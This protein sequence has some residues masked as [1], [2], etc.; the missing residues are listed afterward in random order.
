MAG[1]DLE[2]IVADDELVTRRGVEL[3]LRDSGFRIAG[4]AATVAETRSVL[5]RRRFDVALIE[6]TL[7]GESTASLVGELLAGPGEVPLV[8][9]AGRATP[10]AVL[11]AAAAVDLPGFVLKSSTPAVLLE[12]LRSVAAG[13]RFVDPELARLLPDPHD[14]PRRMGVG[15]LSPRE[16]EILA[17]LA[18]GLS[19][20]DIAG[21]LFLS[22]ETVRTHVRNAIQKLGAR[23]RTQ[24]VAMLVADGGAVPVAVPVD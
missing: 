4:V 18:D 23:T 20:A 11:A 8:L 2:V 7:E 21:H 16:R 6:L 12:A 9:Y 10:T 17:L 22:A 13:G 5:A 15:M 3:L 14:R 1:A 24:A 19:G